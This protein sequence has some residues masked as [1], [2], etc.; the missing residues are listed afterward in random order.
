M[1]ALKTF[2]LFLPIGLLLAQ[3][4]PDLTTSR[5]WETAVPGALG[6][7]D[8]D[9]PTLTWYPPAHASSDAAIIV[10][11]GGS[12]HG[13]ASNHEGRQIANYINGAGLTAF[14]LKYRLGP[15]YHHP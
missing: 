7:D 8:A 12:Y 11:P 13:L 15:R 10:A 9:I 2:V 4:H 14:V 1:T 6:N 5:L 3:T